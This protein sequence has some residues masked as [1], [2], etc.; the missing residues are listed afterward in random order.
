MAPSFL[1]KVRYNCLPSPGTITVDFDHKDHARGLFA[2]S[3]KTNTR[4][5]ISKNEYEVTLPVLSGLDH[6]RCANKANDLVFVFVDGAAMEWSGAGLPLVLIDGDKVRIKRNWVK[7]DLDDELS[8]KT[9]KHDKGKE[10]K[11]GRDADLGKPQRS[12]PKQKIGRK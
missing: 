10:D 1:F 4:C 6:I 8:V 7:K 5:A 2:A 9:T 12:A 11:R 3:Q